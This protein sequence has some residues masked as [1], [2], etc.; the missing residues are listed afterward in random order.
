MGPSE[1]EAPFFM[2]KTR[3]KLTALPVLVIIAAVLFVLI[4]MLD[5]PEPAMEAGVIE[6]EQTEQTVPTTEDPYAFAHTPLDRLLVYARLNDLKLS[7][8]TDDMLNLVQLN[9]DAEE[10]VWNYPAKKETLMEIDLSDQLGTGEV[11]K[12]YQWDERWGYSLYGGKPMGITACGPTC[13]SMVCLYYFQD[14]KYTPRYVAD[15]AEENG[16]YAK[17]YGS[18]WTLMSQ[19]GKKL[20]LDVTAIPP[21]MAQVKQHLEAGELVV[22]CMGPGDF[23]TSGHFI[24]LTGVKD[25]MVTINDPNSPTRTEMLWDL[26]AIKD[27]IENLWVFKGPLPAATET[28]TPEATQ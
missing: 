4:L 8:W 24:L 15:F 9:P 19:G 16:F 17:G 10:Y 1:K 3:K 12:L 27:Q 18:T 5:Q 28:T 13:L 25:G 6:P 21:N 20:G 14:A 7:D 23:T 2:E 26:N 22:F 11:P